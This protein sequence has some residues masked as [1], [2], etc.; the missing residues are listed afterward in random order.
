MPDYLATKY[1][2]VTDELLDEVGDR[3]PKAGAAPAPGAS[4]GDCHRGNILWTDSGP[5]FVDLDDCLTGPAIQDLWMLL[6]GGQQEMRTELAGSA[7]RATSNFC[8]SIAAKS[9]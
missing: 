7:R 1:A 9:R 4:S 3:A 5:H 2:D 8:R 6:A